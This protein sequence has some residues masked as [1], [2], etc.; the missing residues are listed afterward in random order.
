MLKIVSE[1]IS[2]KSTKNVLC[3]LTKIFH[4]WSSYNEII[5]TFFDKLMIVKRPPKDGILFRFKI[6]CGS[7]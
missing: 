6:Y 5:K 2:F 3:K 7:V 1:V 4:I